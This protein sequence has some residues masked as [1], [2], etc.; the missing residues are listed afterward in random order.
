[1]FFGKVSLFNENDTPGYFACILFSFFSPKKDVKM[2][3]VM[4]DC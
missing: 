4:Y 1:M 3:K 2:L